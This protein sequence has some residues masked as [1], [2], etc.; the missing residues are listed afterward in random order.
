MILNLIILIIL[1]VLF[2]LYQSIVTLLFGSGTIFQNTINMFALIAGSLIVFHIFY[3][4]YIYYS[5]M[6]SNGFVG[7]KGIE[8][9]VGQTGKKAQSTSNCGQKVCS[10]LVLEH[11]NKY[12]SLAASPFLPSLFLPPPMCYLRIGTYSGYSSKV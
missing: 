1:F 10:K 6:N 3:N 9:L 5:L 2:I 4:M 11:M 7:P 8:G 12:V